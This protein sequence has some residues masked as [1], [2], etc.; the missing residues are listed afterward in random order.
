MEELE[1]LFSVKEVCFSGLFI[2]SSS[3]FLF[4]NWFEFMIE[5]NAMKIRHTIKQSFRRCLKTSYPVF[6]IFN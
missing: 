3:L 5:F 6:S 1:L 4:Q 2:V